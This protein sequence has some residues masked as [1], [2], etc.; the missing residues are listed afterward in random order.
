MIFF[1]LRKPNSGQNRHQSRS[2]F[3]RKARSRFF[4]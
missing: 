2:T 4:C 3:T 1:W